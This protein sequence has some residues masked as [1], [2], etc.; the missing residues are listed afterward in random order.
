MKKKFKEYELF[1]KLL[2]IIIVALCAQA[3]VISTFIYYRSKNVYIELFNKS[4]AVVLKKIQSDF[5]TLNDNIENTLSLIEDS[6]A[7]EGYFTINSKYTSVDRLGQLLAIQKMNQ[8]FSE[9]YP[10]INYDVVIFG[11]NGR[12]FIGNDMITSISSPEFFKSDLI[13]QFREHA[14]DTQMLFSEN[15][16]TTRDKDEP[17]ILFIKKL[18]DTF[19]RTFGYA[20]VS[21][22]SRQLAEIFNSMINSEISEITF[23]TNENQIIASNESGL[24]GK[25]SEYLELLS[26]NETRQIHGKQTTQLSLYRQNVALISQVNL[27]SLANQMDVIIP[28]ILYNIVTI[29]LIGPLVFTYLN[30]NTK[31]IYTLI[32]SLKNINSGSLETKMP[33]QGTYEVQVLGSTI[34]QLLGELNSYFTN[35]IQ[36]EKKKRFLEIQAMQTQIQPHFIYNTLTTIKFLIWQQENEKAIL[37]IDSFIDLL[38]STIGNKEEMIPVREELKSVKNYI[39]I[40]TLRYGD[41][42]S[43]KV[44]VPDELLDLMMPNMIIQPIIENAYI[45]AFSSKEQGFI[46]IYGKMNESFLIFEIID[47]GNGFDVSQLKKEKKDHFSGL[48]M[49]NVNERIHLMYGSTY[50]MTIQSIIGVGTTVTIKLP[51]LKEETV[52]DV[53]D[54]EE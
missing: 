48:G 5:E 40:L 16:L 31:S 21:I 35:S 19:N 33:V 51:V 22:S 30:R 53:T 47:T 7:V 20:V 3:I 1:T 43:T 26:N 4:N 36:N 14:A 41:T 9:I 38:R 8:S 13:K 42:I 32:H 23:V 2:I 29:I 25:Q 39:D 24:I 52:K 12:T 49:K 27:H 50:G 17:S 28:T 6:S 15:G 37:G 10:K 54:S 34:N 11:E 18:T 44:M 45:H 46:T